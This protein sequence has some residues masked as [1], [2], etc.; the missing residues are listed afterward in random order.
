VAT[1]EQDV[2]PS[3]LCC[4]GWPELATDT[5][6]GSTYVAYGSIVKDKGGLY[7]RKMKPQPEKKGTLAPKSLTGTDFVVP[8]QRMGLVARQGGGVYLAY[9]GG[10]PTCKTVY[11]WKVGSGGP[12]A[13]GTGSSIQDVSVSRGPG[14]RLW[15]TWWD[16]SHVYA[17]RS[18]TG[19]KVW[20][21]PLSV[22]LPPGADHVWK[23]YS[24]GSAKP[25]GP[26]DVLASAGS[27]SFFWHTQ[28]LPRLTVHC[29]HLDPKTVRCLVTDV[30]DHV[31]G[32]KVTF[33]GQTKTTAGTGSA[34]FKSE[35]KALTATATKA[36]YA[37][38]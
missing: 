22:S 19:A 7:V 14:G 11:V 36:G 5:K 8:D 28:V 24:E 15:V 30:T 20:G 16:G 25:V 31:A 27:P 17:V 4:Y 33:A 6:T 1:A 26:V 3:P 35:A 21:A 34:D 38:A 12:K 23:L 10:Y 32:A 2:G 18:N 13:V 29:K 37:S 9:C